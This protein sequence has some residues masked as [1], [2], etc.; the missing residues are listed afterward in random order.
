MAKP[1]DTVPSD[2]K[3]Q[4]APEDIRSMQGDEPPEFLSADDDLDQ[5]DL[6]S[7]DSF[8]A[9]DPPSHTPIRRQ[10]APKDK[11]HPERNSPPPAK[12]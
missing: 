1:Q 3:A 7:E 9:S 10:G 4:P 11:D 12:P 6:S 8:P 5:V 2:S